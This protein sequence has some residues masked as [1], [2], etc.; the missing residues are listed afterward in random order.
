[1]Y[2]HMVRIYKGWIPERFPEVQN[3]TFSLVHI[4]VDLYEP[5]LESLKFFYE[6]MT[7]CGVILCDDYGSLSCPGAKRAF[8]EFFSDKPEALIELPTAQA[9]I[10]KK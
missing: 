10:V 1:M 5:T 9:L 7:P 8:D 2:E 6:R 4:D 3:T